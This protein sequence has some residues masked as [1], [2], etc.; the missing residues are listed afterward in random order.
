LGVADPFLGGELSG[1]AFS[2]LFLGK[3]S[4]GL[5]SFLS[6]LVVLFVGG[7][8]NLVKGL[9]VWVE[10][11]KSLSVGEWVLSSSGDWSGIVSLWSDDALD[12][13]GVDDL[14]DIRVG[15]QMSLEVVSRLALGG[16]SVGTE[17][18]VEGLESGLSPDDESADLTTWGELSEVK[19]SDIN[20]FN[21]RDVSDG[22]GELSAFTVVN[23]E[24][25]LSDL[26]VV[27]SG[28]SNTRSGGLG[29]NDLFDVVVNTNSLQEGNSFLGL[30]NTFELVVNNQWDQWSL[31]DS[32]SSGENERDQSRS[33]QSGGNGMS[34][35]LKVDLSVPSSPGL[36]WGEHS[37]LSAHVTEGTLTVSA[38]TR[39]TD[40]WN[41]GHS[42]TSTP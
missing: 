40:S 7:L 38:G 33:S 15:D 9:G 42:S 24:W 34:S 1:L 2:L 18:L 8:F 31:F 20:D 39:T 16:N 5:K 19:S 41:S 27:A 32:V 23:K 37:T 29:V 36:D 10:L 3:G 30:F 21:T 11:F 6:L 13:V 12:F 4:L 25:T 28:F 26:V 22:L 14:S 17:N 35:L